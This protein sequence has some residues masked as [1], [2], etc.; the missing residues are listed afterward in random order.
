M[1]GKRS[2]KKFEFEVQQQKNYLKE[3]LGIF[4]S[5]KWVATLWKHDNEKVSR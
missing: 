1:A 5:W 4:F 2:W 3:N